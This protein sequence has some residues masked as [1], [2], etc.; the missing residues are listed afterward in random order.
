MKGDELDRAQLIVAGEAPV[1][2]SSLNSQE[3]E[4]LVRG[5]GQGVGTTYASLNVMVYTTVPGPSVRV[6][7]VGKAQSSD[8]VPVER[9]DIA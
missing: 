9:H 7:E 5:E 6:M 3:R 1:V 8:A 4:G 2:P